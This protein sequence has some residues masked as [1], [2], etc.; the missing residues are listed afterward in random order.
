MNGIVLILAHMLTVFQYKI[1]NYWKTVNAAA[2]AASGP[3]CIYPLVTSECNHIPIP[4][5]VQVLLEL[6]QRS[7]T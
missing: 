1:H 2:A 6:V 7:S 5:E 4:N 3:V